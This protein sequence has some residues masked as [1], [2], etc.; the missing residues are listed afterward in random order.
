MGSTGFHPHAH[1][2]VADGLFRPTGTFSCQ[3]KTNP[4]ELDE[5]FRSK[6]PAM[7]S[8]VARFP[9]SFGNRR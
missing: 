9:R 1:A 5:I 4:K 3:P 6:V 8:A 7:L 2:I